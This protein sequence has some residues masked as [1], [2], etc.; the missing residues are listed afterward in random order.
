MSAQKIVLTKRLQ[1]GNATIR[2][3]L[4]DTDA[5]LGSGSWINVTLRGLEDSATYARQK[6]DQYAAIA[7]E[8][9][10]LVA[11]GGAEPW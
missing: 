4:A 3:D 8:L 9:D 10:K 6:A 11:S 2:A 7:D 1:A 5:A